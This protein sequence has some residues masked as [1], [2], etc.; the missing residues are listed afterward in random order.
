MAQEKVQLMTDLE[1]VKKEL[2]NS[3]ENSLARLVFAH[4]QEV[5]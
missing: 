3:N 2:V 1:T 4:D 5:N